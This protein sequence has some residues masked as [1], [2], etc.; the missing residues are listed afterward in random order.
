MKFILLLLVCT[1]MISTSVWG[2]SERHTSP[3]TANPQLCE[4]LLVQKDSTALIYALAP[5]YGP[6]LFELFPYDLLARSPMAAQPLSLELLDIVSWLR[7]TEWKDHSLADFYKAS[8]A[9]RRFGYRWKVGGG[10]IDESPLELL[11]GEIQQDVLERLLQH[12]SKF[13]GRGAM[14]V[15]QRVEYLY[16]KAIFNRFRLQPRTAPAPEFL[17]RKFPRRLREDVVAGLN[18]R[19]NHRA[20]LMWR[21]FWDITIKPALPMTPKKYLH[22]LDQMVEIEPITD[23]LRNF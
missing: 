17:L 10:V 13:E 15:R 16:L 19:R 11:P 1:S 6:T 12:L 22:V 7:L 2:N 23:D 8:P 14:L 5:D 20:E 9:H 21:E 3:Q 18:P 4:Y